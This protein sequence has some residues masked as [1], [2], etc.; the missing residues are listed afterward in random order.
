MT[1]VVSPAAKT[2]AIE[3]RCLSKTYSGRDGPIEAVQSL[4]LKVAAGTIFGL[5]GPNGAGKTTT[6]RML[7]GLISPS[8]GQAL[9]QGRLVEDDPVEIRR[10][11]GWLPEHIRA[12]QELTVAEELAYY[13]G[14]YGLSSGQVARRSRP[15]LERLGLTR[16]LHDR[17]AGFSKGMTR[18]VQLI[19]VLLHQPSIL[20]LDEPTSG[21][22]PAIVEQVELFLRELVQDSSLTILLSSHHLD[23]VERLCQR[24]GIL[25]SRLLVEAP[26]TELTNRPRRYQIRLAQGAWHGLESVLSVPGV[27]E[28]GSEGGGLSLTLDGD[29]KV[30]IPEVVRR[31][32]GAGADVITVEP[33]R[34]DLRS[35]YLERIDSGVLAGGDEQ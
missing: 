33:Q 22:D 15:Y 12:H 27:A 2:V 35:V 29:P 1:A 6:I 16:R 28:A 34:T 23:V 32:V 4:D 24:V 19:R 13:G 14:L 11:I 17:L 9:I 21:L 30:A 8:A 25:Q 10:C 3:T 7:C 20:L 26:L 5:L 18:K 31:L